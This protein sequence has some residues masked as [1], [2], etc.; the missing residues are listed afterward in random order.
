MKK[1]N[2]IIFIVLVLLS[3]FLLWLWYYLGLNKI[4]NPLDLV[5]SIIWWALIIVAVIVIV[6]LEKARRQRIRTVYVTEH[7]VYNSEA[8]IIPYDDSV[9]LVAI[10]ESILK[11]LTYNFKRKDPPDNKTYP[12]RL[13]VHTDRFKY[14]NNDREETWEGEVVIAS[15]KQ[16]ESYDNKSELFNILNRM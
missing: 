5:L 10:L 6:R 4:D 13:L 2:V 11:N 3:A 14:D 1:N 15:T 8:G 9:R 16:K 12:F 7:E